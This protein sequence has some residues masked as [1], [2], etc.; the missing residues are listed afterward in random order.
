MHYTQI[1]LNGRKVILGENKINS[2]KPIRLLIAFHG[3]ESSPERM[4]IHGNRLELD[5]ILM[6]FPEGLIEINEG[7]FSWWL[8]GPKQSKTVEKFLNYCDGLIEQIQDYLKINSPKKRTKTLLW[9]FSQ[10]GAA[11]LT[12]ALL[13]RHHIYK[14]ASVCGFL[15]ETPKIPSENKPRADILG[16]FGSNDQVVPNFLAEHALSEMGRYGHKMIF[17]ETSQ[18]HEIN[19]QNLIKIKEFFADKV[20]TL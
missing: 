8:D 5:N 17:C 10:G 2:N 19:T 1:Q 9:G 20:P 7:N 15:P 16:I 13:G 14:V 3:A 18:G 11:A 6:A 4:L 12:Y